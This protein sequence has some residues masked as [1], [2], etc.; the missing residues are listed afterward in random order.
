MILEFGWVTTAGFAADDGY[1]IFPMPL[2]LLELLELLLILCTSSSSSRKLKTLALDASFDTTAVIVDVGLIV[3]VVVV[4]GI[5]VLFTEEDE[6]FFSAFVCDDDDDD[7]MYACCWSEYK[8][9]LSDVAM[10]HIKHKEIQKQY[11]NK[12]YMRCIQY[13]Q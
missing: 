5:T 12:K 7:D 2:K 3:V 4:E 9:G 13:Y 6:L 8:A 10:N 11:H 1:E